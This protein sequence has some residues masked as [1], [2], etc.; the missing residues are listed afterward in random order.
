MDRLKLYD[1]ILTISINKKDKIKFK[2]IAFKNKMTMSEF[3]RLLIKTAILI[4]DLDKKEID[5][6]KSTTQIDNII[7][8]IRRDS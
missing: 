5:T 8:T 6:I 4:N 1:D 7:S 3:S 2:R